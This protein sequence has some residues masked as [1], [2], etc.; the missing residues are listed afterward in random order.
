MKIPVLGNLDIKSVLVGAAI[1]WL[2]DT[3]VLKESL[4]GRAYIGET[5]NTLNYTG[6]PGE[7]DLS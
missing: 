7:Y 1:F 4:T 6:R 5:M 3:Y 2:V